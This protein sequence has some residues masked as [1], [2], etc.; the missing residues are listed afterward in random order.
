SKQASKQDFINYKVSLLSGRNVPRHSILCASLRRYP[1]S[2]GFFVP[3]HGL[4]SP[5]E[6]ELEST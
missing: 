5:T 3:G 6:S 4:H 1:A 2:G